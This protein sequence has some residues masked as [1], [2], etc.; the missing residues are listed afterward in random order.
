MKVSIRRGYQRSPSGQILGEHW[1]VR[2]GE[3]TG[4]GI[5]LRDAKMDARHNRI[6]TH[7]TE[8]THDRAHLPVKA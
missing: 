2:M 5:T 7:K 4:E 3:T 8:V 1:V 6:A